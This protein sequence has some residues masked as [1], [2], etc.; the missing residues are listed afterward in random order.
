MGGRRSRES[1][2]L[3]TSSEIV[4]EG[5]A[6]AV[7]LNDQIQGAPRRPIRRNRQRDEAVRFPH[8]APLL[9]SGGPSASRSSRSVDRQGWTEQT[10]SSDA[11]AWRRR[12]RSFERLMAVSLG[13]L[14]PRVV[15]GISPPLLPVEVGLEVKGRRSRWPPPAAVRGAGGRGGGASPQEGAGETIAISVHL[16]VTPRLASTASP[17]LPSSKGSGDSLDSLISQSTLHSGAEDSPTLLLLFAPPFIS[18][19]PHL[20]RPPPFPPR[21][22][23]AG[24][25]RPP[26]AAARTRRLAFA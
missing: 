15:P 18:L 26:R 2:V 16:G 14:L 25:R 7:G 19:P 9:R 1:W 5:R 8:E 21:V 17:R 10:M 4:S 20:P 22:R 11:K 23:A 6:F 13:T 24:N 3:S 12:L